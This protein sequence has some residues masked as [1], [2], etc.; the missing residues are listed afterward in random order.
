MEG[1]THSQYAASSHTH[2]D[3][4]YT[5]SETNSLLAGKAASSHTHTMDQ[6]TGILPVEKGGTGVTSYS[7][8]A[9]QINPY[10]D[11]TPSES[12][13]EFNANKTLD[14]GNSYYLNNGSTGNTSQVQDATMVFDMNISTIECNILSMSTAMYAYTTTGHGSSTAGTVINKT[15]TFTMSANSNVTLQTITVPNIMVAVLEVVAYTNYLKVQ[16]RYVSSA[17][18]GS[19]WYAYFLIQNIHMVATGIR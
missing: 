7:A 17:G 1:H 3:R 19:S 16:F 13:R 15:G 2:D 8:L 11:L 5:E 9:T 12:V 18:T 6:L 14:W 4:Y 10:L